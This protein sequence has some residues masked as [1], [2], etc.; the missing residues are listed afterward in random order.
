LGTKFK[1]PNRPR[2]FCIIPK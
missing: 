1:N 2:L